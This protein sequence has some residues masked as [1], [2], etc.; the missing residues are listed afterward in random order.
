VRAKRT[1]LG[2]ILCATGIFG[3]FWVELVQGNLPCKLCLIIRY[4]LASAG[5]I[6]IISLFYEKIK[7]L[8]IFPTIPAIMA[9]IVLIINERKIGKQGICEGNICQTPEF[10]GVK[11]SIW[12]LIIILSLIFLS[13]YEIKEEFAK[14]KR[15][16]SS[17]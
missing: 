14:I 12:A 1:L 3:S 9:D 4:S 13:V 16:N 2:I 7:M 8:S 6:F 10:L 11:T 17:T 15:E 5:A